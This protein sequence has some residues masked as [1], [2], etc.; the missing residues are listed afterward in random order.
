MPNTTKTA[1]VD[2]IHNNPHQ[3]P[4][5]RL[6]FIHEQPGLP[7]TFEAKRG[8]D[9]R[10]VCG[11]GRDPTLS[12]CPAGVA[13]QVLRFRSRGPARATG[14]VRRTGRASPCR[15]L[16][17]RA[18]AALSPATVRSR[19]SSRSRLVVS[20]SARWPAST[21]RPT[22]RADRY[23]HRVDQVGEVPTQPV[24]LPDDELVALPQGLADSCRVPAGRRGRRRRGRGSWPRH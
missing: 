23:P 20:V 3:Q 2:S 1:A 17:P 4:G 22:P 24:E 7:I 10:V 15:P 14:L 12:R 13:A 11:R 16:R 8:C 21:R 5:P 6:A 19:I 18:R 9:Q